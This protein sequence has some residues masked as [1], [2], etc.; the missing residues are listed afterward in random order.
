[1]R[2]GKVHYVGLSNFT[3]WQLEHVM[4]TARQLGAYAPVSLQQQYSMLSRESEWEVVPACLHN[5]I[6]ILPWSPLA[7]GFLTGKYQRGS[8]PAPGTRAG[9]KKPL[10]QWVSAEYAASA[11]N[12]TTIETVVRVAHELGATTSARRSAVAA[13]SA[14]GSDRAA[15]TGGTCVRVVTA[16]GSEAP[17][18]RT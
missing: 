3:G 10:Y 4:S 15:L 18:G 17:L 9:S 13:R 6:T 11:R 16:K 1:M 7:G 5:G 2:A 14:S 12:W 8:M